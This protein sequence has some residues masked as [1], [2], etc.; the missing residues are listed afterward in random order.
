MYSKIAF[1]KWLFKEFKSTTFWSNE[2]IMQAINEIFCSEHLEEIHKEW[3][4]NSSKRFYQGIDVLK[5]FK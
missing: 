1:K 2:N 3:R 5:K 4:E